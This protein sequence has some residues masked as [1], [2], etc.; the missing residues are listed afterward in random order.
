MLKHDLN[1]NFL[2]GQT[3]KE[4][5]SVKMATSSTEPSVRRNRYSRSSTTSVT[6]LL[7]ESCSS[8]LHRLTRRGPSE[9]PAY[10]VRTNTTR[11]EEKPTD[12]VKI[13]N[14]IS[15]AVPAT[16][17]AALGS[18]RSRLESKYSAVLDR[19]KRREVIDH[20]K[21]LEPS[22]LRTHVTKKSASSVNIGEKAYPYVSALEQSGAYLDRDDIYRLRHRNGGK[23][24]HRYQPPP[25]DNEAT[26]TNEMTER[27]AKRKEIQSLILKYAQLDDRP[28]ERLYPAVN[29]D[30]PRHQSQSQTQNQAP[31]LQKYRKQKTSSVLTS[32]TVVSHLLPKNI[33]ARPSL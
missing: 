17:T 21:T 6:Q 18:T 9:K 2:H 27:E 22:P 12:A 11:P 8:L 32:S 25:E 16:T 28:T 1:L 10:R 30:V 31:V 26:P 15:A 5:K 29:G 23:H 33:D 19:V 13:Q 20:D 3:T 4:Q 14:K 24:A 7:S